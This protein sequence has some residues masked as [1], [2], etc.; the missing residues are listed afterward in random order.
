MSVYSEHIEHLAAN[1]I[2]EEFFNS[3]ELHAEIVLTS[4]IRHAKQKVKIFSGNMCSD[5]SNNP[6]YLNEIKS[7]LFDRKGTLEI[8][9]CDGKDRFKETEI[10]RILNQFIPD[11]VQIKTTKTLL[12]FEDKPIHFTVADD[13]AFRLETDIEK[14]MARGNF[15]DPDSGQML[16]KRFDSLFQTGLPL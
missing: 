11:Q 2:D 1:S 6:N 9:F 12:L 4:M 13:T 15:H 16:S 8:L 7:F 3:N 14:R 10:Y 5:V